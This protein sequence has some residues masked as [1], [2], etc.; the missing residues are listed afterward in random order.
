MFYFLKYSTSNTDYSI[1]GIMLQSAGAFCNCCTASVDE[2]ME[3]SNIVQG[4]YIH[5]YIHNIKMKGFG[6]FDNIL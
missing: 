3:L 1:I 5:T 4:S 6:S 2:A